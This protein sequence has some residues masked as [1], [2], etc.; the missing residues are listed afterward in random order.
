[1]I[2]GDKATFAIEAMLEPFPVTKTSVWGRM[3]LWCE[4]TT[5]GD[6]AVEHCALYP[7]YVSFKA[8]IERITELWHPSFTGLSNRELWERLH[9]LAWEDDSCGEVLP[10]F[11]D[12]PG[13]DVSDL[14]CRFNFLSGWGRSFDG[15]GHCYLVCAPNQTVRILVDEAHFGGELTSTARLADFRAATDGYLQWFEDQNAT[16]EAST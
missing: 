6:I 11:D 5:I 2:F 10:P 3:Q 1:M 16:A 14:Y 8:L 7:S 12:Q 15:L 9:R 13:V 4:D